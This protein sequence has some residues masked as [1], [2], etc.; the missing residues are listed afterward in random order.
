L[1][2][3]RWNSE[4]RGHSTVERVKSTSRCLEKTKI[5]PREYISHARIQYNG[6]H[7]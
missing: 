5:P 2:V 4:F 1:L 6:H 3:S 7:E